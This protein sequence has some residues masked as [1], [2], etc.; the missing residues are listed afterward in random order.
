[1]DEQTF[2]DLTGI[3]LDQ[4]ESDRFDTVLEVATKQLE[5]QL[6]Y[7]LDP[8]DWANLYNETGKTT[9]DCPCP[10]VDT[11][12]LEDP[13]P[14]VGKYRLF[15]WYPT[16]RF[17]HI[18]PATAV[19]RVKLVNNSVTY[20]TFNDEG[21]NQYLVKWE[22]N[23]PRFTRYLDLSN[24]NW[25]PECWRSMP[26]VQLAVDA[27]WAWST[28]PT[29]LNQAFADMIAKLYE[30]SD[31]ELQ[32]ETRGSHSYTKRES[33]GVSQDL[34]SRYPV[35]GE[36]AGPNGLATPRRVV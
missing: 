20:K 6:G 1:M 4:S 18:D 14:V 31:P 33:Q 30:R 13:D 17:L 24:C 28:A 10:D 21:E 35:L 34:A 36:L 26:Y 16:D 11:D 7:P 19:H 12:E 23:S 25:L 3:T 9:G 5:R 2:A 32:S 22:N 8:S 29:E 27:T 15:S